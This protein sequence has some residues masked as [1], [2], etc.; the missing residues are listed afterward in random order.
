MADV[1]FADADEEGFFSESSAAAFGALGFAAKSGQDDA[2]LDFIRLALDLP[3]VVVNAGHVGIAVP[4]DA[5][6][7]F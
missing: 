5:S 7:F 3:E 2:V 1:L 4:E 6:V